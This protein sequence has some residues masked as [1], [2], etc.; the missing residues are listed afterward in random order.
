MSN[1]ELMREDSQLPPPEICKTSDSCQLESLDTD[2][3]YAESLD[4]RVFEQVQGINV[5][6]EGWAIVTRNVGAYISHDR[7]SQQMYTQSTQVT[8]DSRRNTSRSHD[9]VIGQHV[10]HAHNEAVARIGT[11]ILKDVYVD[12]HNLVSAGAP[13]L[14]DIVGLEKR[15]L[16]A[17]RKRT[18]EIGADR[19]FVVEDELTTAFQL[20][21]AI[22]A[23]MQ[24]INEE[25]PDVLQAMFDPATLNDL[26]NALQRIAALDIKRGKSSILLNN[27]E[28]PANADQPMSVQLAEYVRSNHLPEGVKKS[29]QAIKF[30]MKVMGAPECPFNDLGICTHMLAKLP[31][32]QYPDEIQ[33]DIANRANTEVQRRVESLILFSRRNPTGK[34]LDSTLYLAE[35]MTVSGSKAKKRASAPKIESRDLTMV[36]NPEVDTPAFSRVKIR[37]ANSDIVYDVEPTIND[38]LEKTLGDVTEHKIVKSYLDKYHDEKL[39]DM[40]GVALGFIAVAPTYAGTDNTVRRWLDKRNQSHVNDDGVKE[41]FM[42]YSGSSASG[43]SGGPVGKDTRIIFSQGTENGVRHITIHKVL[44]KSDIKSNTVI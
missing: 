23:Y 43:T 10:S 4:E 2:Q 40:V 11:G 25:A 24:S 22:R 37:F 33:R 36:E 34:I 1:P 44:H 3:F 31:T 12:D 28:K 38:D 26:P 35:D 30:G 6:V 42:R 15:I 13:L 29:L 9:S 32:T 8:R 16:E 20:E 41:K 17:Q 27:A 21:F 19:R 39:N 14:K 5:A 7:Q 18:A